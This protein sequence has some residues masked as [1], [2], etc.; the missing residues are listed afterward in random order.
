M[1]A[2][3]TVGWDEIEALAATLAAVAQ[4]CAPPGGYDRVVAVARGGLVPA[5]L[6]AGRLDVARVEG[7]QVRAYAGR[8]GGTQAQWVG[9]PP[10]VA[11]PSG[12][13]AR[14]LVVD[15]LVEGGAT[16][17][18]VGAALPLAKLAVLLVKGSLCAGSA[19]APGAVRVAALEARGVC[20]PVL[21]A[22]CTDAGAWLVFPWTP[23]AERGG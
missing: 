2:T 16:L 3:R 5:A 21:A 4:A 12:E 8:Q 23:P 10:A 6:L 22:T 14:T 7:V 18:C 15:E 9:P 19:P 1:A 17:A 20:R 11:G 13:P